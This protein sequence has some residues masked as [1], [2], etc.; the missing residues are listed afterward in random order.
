MY[1]E[2]FQLKTQPF[3]E[4]AAA[5]SLWIDSTDARKAWRG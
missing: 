1:Q 2:H 5:T 3:S 4:H